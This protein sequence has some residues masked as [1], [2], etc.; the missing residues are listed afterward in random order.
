M[1]ILTAK[2]VSPDP[3]F[4]STTELLVLAS[5][6]NVAKCDKECEWQSHVT[7]PSTVE[8]WQEGG[9]IEATPMAPLQK[10]LLSWGSQVRLSVV[11]SIDNIPKPH[12]G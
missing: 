7:N 10:I 12:C 11:F 6:K 5:M 2:K 9:T 1:Y 3:P 8:D 4:S